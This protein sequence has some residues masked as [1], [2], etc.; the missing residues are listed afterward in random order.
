[1]T[2]AVTVVS[3]AIVTEPKVTVAPLARGRTSR[4]SAGA[5]APIRGAWRCPIRVPRQHKLDNSRRLRKRGFL[6]HL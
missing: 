2:I 6:A 1:M 3:L 4:T 5:R